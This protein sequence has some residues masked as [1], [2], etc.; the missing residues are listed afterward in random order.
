MT[1]HIV[2]DV[3]LLI[4]DTTVGSYLHPDLEY[5]WYMGQPWRDRKRVVESERMHLAFLDWFPQLVHPSHTH[6]VRLA[7]A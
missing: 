4:S 3:L 1:I 7:H 6:C 5:Y 2:T